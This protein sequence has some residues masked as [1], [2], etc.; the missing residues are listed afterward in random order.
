MQCGL[1]TLSLLAVAEH[2]V[3]LHDV[4]KLAAY[5]EVPDHSV[6]GSL[7]DHTRLVDASVEILFQWRR[8]MGTDQEA[9]QVLV[10]ALQKAGMQRTLAEVFGLAFPTPQTDAGRVRANRLH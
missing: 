7:Q 2:L 1:T 4:R 8:T 5:L 3:G 6:E 9:L 10:Q